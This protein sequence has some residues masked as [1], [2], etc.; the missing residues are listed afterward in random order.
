M[1]LV[2]SVTNEV[3]VYFFLTCF[4]LMLPLT[5]REHRDLGFVWSISCSRGAQ[6]CKKFL[7][8]LAEMLISIRLNVNLYTLNYDIILSTQVQEKSNISRYRR[9]WSDGRIEI[10]PHHLIENQTNIG[11]LHSSI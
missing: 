11:V 7:L 10:F 4:I 5:F 1:D 2:V 3:P 9:W 8:Q 6:T